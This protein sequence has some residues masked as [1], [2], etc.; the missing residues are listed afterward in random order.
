MFQSIYFPFLLNYLSSPSSVLLK[1]CYV[2]GFPGNLIKMQI[3]GPHYQSFWFCRSQCRAANLP[4]PGDANAAG[5][6]T[7][8]PLQL[9]GFLFLKKKSTKKI[10]IQIWPSALVRK[11][12]PNLVDKEL[13]KIKN[14]NK[15][16]FLK[17]DKRRIKGTIRYLG[18]HLY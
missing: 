14:Y 1:L 4:F 5:L 15:A 3:C 11:P 18:F 12:C 2:S 7:S 10:D 8:D 6:R 13:V 9:T 17:S 16:F